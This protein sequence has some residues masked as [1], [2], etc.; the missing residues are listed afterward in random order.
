[1]GAYGEV[2]NRLGN[3]NKCNWAGYDDVISP[4]INV[5]SRLQGRSRALNNITNSK[6]WIIH[7]L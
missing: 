3:E 5:S 6:L 1:M 4:F 2:V 7:N